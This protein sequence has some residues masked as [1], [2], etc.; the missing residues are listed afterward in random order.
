MDKRVDIEKV[1]QL[2]LADAHNARESAGYSGSWSDGGASVLEAQ[3]QYYRYGM[4]GTIPPDWSKYARQAEVAE[5]PEYAEY[6]RLHAKFKDV[7]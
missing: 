3:V 6:L 5:D 4:Q 2:I 7:K 1:M